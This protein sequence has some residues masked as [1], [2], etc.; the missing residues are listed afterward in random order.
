MG[1]L[2]DREFEGGYTFEENE[3]D[4]GDKTPEQIWLGK[5]FDGQNY[6]LTR[7]FYLGDQI[8][9]EEKRR[10]ITILLTYEDEEDH[11]G[12]DEVGRKCFVLDNMPAVMRI[13]NELD[14]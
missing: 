4:Y 11:D 12:I 9:A 8:T 2:V 7:Q 3:D 5:A 13:L 6:A 14:P 10:L 1:A